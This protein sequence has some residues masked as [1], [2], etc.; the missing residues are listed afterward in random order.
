MRTRPTAK[1]T[2][3]S[4]FYSNQVKRSLPFAII[5]IALGG[6]VA[7]GL[8]LRHSVEGSAASTVAASSRA[9]LSNPS[10]TAAPATGAEPAHIRGPATATLTLEE[11]ADFECPAC[12]KFYP[13]LKSIEAEYGD[14]LRVIFREFPL[15]QHRNAVTAGRAAEAAGVQGKFWEMHD[16]LYENRDT[17]SKAAGVQPIFEEYARRLGLDVEQFKRDQ[18]SEIVEKRIALDHQ[19]GRSLRLRATPTIYLNG[20]EIP[21]AQMKTIEDLRAVLDKDLKLAGS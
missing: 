6:G 15:A 10:A 3:S 21:Y 8:Y 12:G 19:R 4:S 20:N 9:D 16:L 17:W 5:M 13:V 7:L 1:S 2:S 14:R 11:F 18:T